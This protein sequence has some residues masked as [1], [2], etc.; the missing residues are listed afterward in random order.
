MRRE[1]IE[2]LRE[3]FFDSLNEYYGETPIKFDIEKDLFDKII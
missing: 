1:D 3:Y 2:E